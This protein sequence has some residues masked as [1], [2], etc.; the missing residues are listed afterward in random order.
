MRV[1]VVVLVGQAMASMDASILAVASPSLRADLHASDAQLQLVVATYTMA[2]A[3]FVVT[4]ARLGDV[5]GRR[6]A[7][8]LGLAGFTAASL[9]GGLA[10]TSAVLIG[11]RTLQGA[12]AAVMTPQV[13]SIIQLQFDG[14]ARARAVGAYSM[15]LAAGVAAGQVLGGLLVSADL[16]AAAWRP[17]LLLNAPVGAAL[18]LAARRGLPNMRRG[19]TRRPDPAG[20]AVLAV[21]L[22][23]LV[24]PLTFGRQAGWPPWVWLSVAVAVGLIAGFVAVERSVTA[25]GGDPLFDLDVWTI[26]GVAAGVGAITLIMA[27]YAGFLISLTLHL[28]EG[29]GFS[30]LHAGLTFA[31]YASGFGTFSLAWTRAGE[32]WRERLPVAGALAMG[33]ALLGI[34]FVAAGGGWPIALT[35][36]LLFCGGGGHACGFSPLA[37]R[38]TTLVRHDQAADLSG[39]VLTASLLGQVLGV[40]VF[41]GVYFGGLSHGSAP[42]L[43]HTTV[44]LAGGMLAT[45]ICAATMNRVLARR[46]AVSPADAAS[47]TR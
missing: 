5:L 24:I 29:L 46:T 10:P 37:S 19:A 40:A 31:A 32:R 4:G 13:L 20:T 38:L 12:A 15:V 16:L 30:P 34:G 6:R 39:L 22:L 41:T 14:D 33:A 2:F 36:A 18:L 23:A 3:A 11:A 9:A 17:A 42:A 28:Q 26:P 7:F 25:R 44:A 47:D 45:T 21:A 8:L 1:L 35:T 27:C 43:A